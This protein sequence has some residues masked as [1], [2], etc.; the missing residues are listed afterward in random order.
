MSKFLLLLKVNLT[1]ILNPSKIV[2]NE[3]SKDKKSGLSSKLLVV[4]LAGCL[5]FSCATNIILV[6][7]T[8]AEMN[9]IDLI[10]PIGLIAT[11]FVILFAT[12]YQAQSYLFNVKDKD[13]LLSIPVSKYTLMISK[14]STLYIESLLFSLLIVLPLGCVYTYYT[15]FSVEFWIM[16]IVEWLFIPM[17][18]LIIS[19]IIGYLLGLISNKFKHKNLVTIVISIGLILLIMYSSF[20]MEGFMN[21]I[22]ENVKS[23][24]EMFFKLYFPSQFFYNSLVNFEILDL[25]KFVLISLLPAIL[26]TYVLSLRYFKILSKFS[27]SSAKSNYTMK[28]L[29]KSNIIT[30]LYKKEIKRYLSSYIYVLNTSIGM[31]MLLAISFILLFSGGEVLEKMIEI[32]GISEILPMFSI[33]AMCLMVSM[34]STTCSSISTEGNNLWIAKSLPM[35][36]SNIFISKILVNL[37]MI[38]PAL[39]LSI[40]FFVFSVEYTVIQLVIAFVLPTILAILVSVFGLMVNLKYPRT[41]A[42]DVVIVKQSASVFISMIGSMLL[43]VGF[44]ALY[45]VK[46]SDLISFEFYAL[47]LGLVLCLATVACIIIINTKGKEKFL[48]L[49]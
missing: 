44:I 39:Y 2:K 8:L 30:A 42:S 13:F 25:L 36:I 40:L 14:I 1:S 45:L 38:L 10:L 32:P 31:I 22:T 35:D 41:D 3:Y 9:M 26:F 11:S 23:I 21:Y 6:A 46:V 24:Q 49:Q 47:I 28:K 33:A 18:P 17:I 29:K 20:N 27:E 12:I 43:M 7:K 4:I 15:S 37:T 16:Y 34:S 48:E 5:L 19:V